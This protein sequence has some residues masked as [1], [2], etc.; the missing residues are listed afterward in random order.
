MQKRDNLMV[1][2]GDDKSVIY[3]KLICDDEI[4]QS[5]SQQVHISISVILTYLYILCYELTFQLST[6]FGD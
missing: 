4:C 1:I 5:S 6:D 2:N 3:L